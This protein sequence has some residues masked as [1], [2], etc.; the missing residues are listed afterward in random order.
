M[1]SCDNMV[2]HWE[3]GIVSNKNWMNDKSVSVLLTTVE[4]TKQTTMYLNSLVK[5][6][7]TW[8]SLRINLVGTQYILDVLVLIF[9]FMTVNLSDFKL[10]KRGWLFSNIWVITERL[11]DRYWQ[12]KFYLILAILV[13]TI[14]CHS[15]NYF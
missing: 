11:L 9:E 1:R 7:C 2:K 6:F 13:K 14:S 15:V 4:Y 12:F 5:P 10:N 3:L 8:W